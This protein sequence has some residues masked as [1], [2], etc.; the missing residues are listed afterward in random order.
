MFGST[1]L[2]SVAF[3]RSDDEI[4]GDASRVEVQ[5]D[6]DGEGQSGGAAAVGLSHEERPVRLA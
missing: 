6:P 4:M 5:G 2:D 1:Y 3:G